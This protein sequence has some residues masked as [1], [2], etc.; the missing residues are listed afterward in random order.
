M[1]LHCGWYVSCNLW[2]TADQLKSLVFLRNRQCGLGRSMTSH[3][4]WQLME[5]HWLAIIF[6]YLK[7]FS[8][9][10]SF[11]MLSLSWMCNFMNGCHSNVGVFNQ[12]SFL[13]SVLVRNNLLKRHY[14][15]PVLSF[16]LFGNLFFPVRISC[17]SC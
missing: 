7:C 6:K 3:G 1:T 13:W 9:I 4:S 17:H 11:L 8:I 2:L 12:I 14:V 5:R 15:C 16:L 10:S